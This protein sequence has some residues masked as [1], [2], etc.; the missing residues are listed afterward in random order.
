MTDLLRELIVKGELPPG[1]H[2][3]T[4]AMA[5]RMGVSLSPVREAISRLAKDGLVESCPYRGACVV[6]LTPENGKDLYV[7][8]SVLGGLAA[9]LA[10]VHGG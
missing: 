10:T 5:E 3:K 7:L 9:R 8:R 1:S 2:L 6:Q 4:N